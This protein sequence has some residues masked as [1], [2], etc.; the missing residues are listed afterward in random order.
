VKFEEEWCCKHDSCKNGVVLSSHIQFSV[1]ESFSNK[2]SSA[3]F[4]EQAINWSR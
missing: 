2:L 1:K 3:L 4:V